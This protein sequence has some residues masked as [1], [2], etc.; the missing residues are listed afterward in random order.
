[1]SD[2]IQAGRAYSQQTQNYQWGFATRTRASPA[3]FHLAL[4]ARPQEKDENCPVKLS[5]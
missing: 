4:N 1:M 3:I 5:K 2:K